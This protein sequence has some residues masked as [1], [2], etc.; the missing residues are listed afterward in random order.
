MF[1]TWKK[2]FF[3]LKK[4]KDENEEIYSNAWRNNPERTQRGTKKS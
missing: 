1:Y 2:I 3:N 4:W